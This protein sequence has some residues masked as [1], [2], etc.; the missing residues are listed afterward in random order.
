MFTLNIMEYWYYCKKVWLNVIITIINA[1]GMFTLV[2]S[3]YH[4][5]IDVVAALIFSI[6]FWIIYHWAVSIPQLQGTWWGTIINWIDDPFYYER[7][8]LPI[9]YGKSNFVLYLYICIFII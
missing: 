3:S 5:S 6:I 7:S 2:M 8:T 9:A 4:Y 1:V